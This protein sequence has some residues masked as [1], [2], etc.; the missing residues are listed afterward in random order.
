MCVLNSM[1]YMPAYSCT[2]STNAISI[3]ATANSSRELCS[4]HKPFT[5]AGSQT[6]LYTHTYPE[7]LCN[8]P[9]YTLKYM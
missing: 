5:S 6:N 4:C 1:Q 2:Y 8:M 7:Y 9:S 3:S